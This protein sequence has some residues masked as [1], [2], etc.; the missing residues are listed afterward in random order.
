[1]KVMISDLKDERKR[2]ILGM[3]GKKRHLILGLIIILNSIMILNSST[4]NVSATGTS[5]VGN[6]SSNTTWTSSGS[7]YW[8]EDS[9]TVL[10]DVNLTIEP[11]VEV[12]F[13]GFY[14]LYIEGALNATG[15]ESN[16]IN[17]T[18]NK[19][20]PSSSDWN[21]ISVNSTGHVEIKH[22]NV[23]Y[24]DYGLYIRSSNNN[25]T[26]STF[27]NNLRGAYLFFLSNANNI[28]NNNVSDNGDGIYLDMNMNNIVINNQL[29]NNIYCSLCVSGTQKEMY[30]H[31]IPTSNII[32]GKPFYHFYDMEDTLISDLDAGH[33]ILA[34]SNNTTLQ[35]ISI[36]NGD[37]IDFSFT[38]NSTVI[39]SNSSNSWY[40][41]W[42]RDSAN[43]T[44]KNNTLT[45]NRRLGLDI[46]WSPNI[47]IIHNNISNNSLGIYL[48]TSPNSTI[49]DN[50]I[51]NN[52]IGVFDSYKVR[53]ENNTLSN[54]ST[55]I[56]IK[57]SSNNTILK[58]RIIENYNKGIYL[59][60]SFNC[61]L[62]NNSIEKNSLGIQIE[63]ASDNRILD[64]TITQNSRG[65]SFSAFSSNNLINNNII[66]Y[67]RFDGI[68]IS[69]SSENTIIEND[70][71]YNEDRG[72]FV[73]SF[74]TS[75][76]IFHNN[77]IGNFIQA[78][79]D[80]NANFW[81]DTYPSGG[82]YWSDYS[83]GCQDLY[84]G[85]ITPQLAGLPDNICDI[86]NDIDADTIDYYPRS[87]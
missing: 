40:G 24:G 53:I 63:S 9:I 76:L 7:P 82:N 27:S 49:M 84:D 10:P 31:T 37:M 12:R 4:E 83:P 57:Y 36:S 73:T 6:I 14:S 33:I 46:H 25:I 19:S 48:S 43:I 16:K 68:Y 42:M 71:S 65:I 61:S 66:S 20:V 15:T 18:S 85:P 62:I 44:I 22:C 45:N 77:I 59:D 74:S 67:S 64:N 70:V 47:D 56:D 2:R 51:L 75:N 1:M 29:W 69:E 79:D 34:G 32:N 28:T 52:G 23:M 17:I 39:Y 60:H 38:T 26:N 41:I 86:Q 35:N 30:N 81:N 78:I 87:R 21:R 8:I 50:D 11:G 3:K 54:D 80:S 55:G 5:V 58:N 13:N 72:F